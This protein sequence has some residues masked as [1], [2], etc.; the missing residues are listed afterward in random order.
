MDNFKQIIE[1]RKEPENIE[2]RERNTELLKAATEG[3]WREAVYI[4]L[5][6][7]QA[8]TK[9]INDDGN[10]MLHKAVEKWQNYFVKKLLEFIENDR[11]IEKQNSDG[12]TALHIAA[13][14][15]NTPAA[16]LLVEKRKELL[17]L[18]DHNALVPLLSAYYNRNFDT[19]AYLLEVAEINNENVSIGFYPDPDILS[20]ATFLVILIFEKNY[21]E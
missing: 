4:L 17:G 3:C 7:K 10:T 15:G 13:I 1:P 5:K 6:D 14:V 19:F 18:A 11:A 21:G 2:T 16:K 12:R 8:A 20:G 9:A